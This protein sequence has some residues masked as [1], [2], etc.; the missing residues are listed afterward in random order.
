[1]HAHIAHVCIYKY[2]CIVY[3]TKYKVYTKYV[4]TINNKYELSCL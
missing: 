4:S 2:V 3:T 1:M